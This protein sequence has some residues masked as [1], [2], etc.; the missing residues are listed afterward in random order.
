MDRKTYNTK[1]CIYIMK[2]KALF[3]LSML[4]VVL[5]GVAQPTTPTESEMKSMIDD[6]WDYNE[7]SLANYTNGTPVNSLH[8]VWLQQFTNNYLNAL[9]CLDDLDRLDQMVTIYRQAL[10]PGAM[11]ST[12]TTIVAPASCTNGNPPY[13]NPVY[14]WRAVLSEQGPKEYVLP[15]AQFGYAVTKMVNVI[16]EIPSDQRTSEMNDLLNDFQVVINDQFWRWIYGPLGHFSTDG[17]GGCSDDCMNHDDFMQRKLEKSLMNPG[18]PSY[19]NIISYREMWIIGAAAE[20]LLAHHREPASVLLTEQ[21]KVFLTDY[22]TTSTRAL[23][24]RTSYTTLTN[25]SGASV[26]GA[27]FDIG[28][29]DDHPV[30]RYSQVT[31]PCNSFPPNDPPFPVNTSTDLSHARL[32]VHIL[33]SLFTAR[34]ITGQ[35]FPDQSVMEAFANQFAYGVFNGEFGSP[36]FSNYTNGDNGWF[37]VNLISNAPFQLGRAAYFGFGFWSKYNPDIAS[38]NSC[39]YNLAIDPNLSAHR[40]AYFKYGSTDTSNCSLGYPMNFSMANSKDMLMFLPSF[41]QHHRNVPENTSLNLASGFNGS[42]G[43][44]IFN[45]WNMENLGHLRLQPSPNFVLHDMVSADF[46]LDGVDEL[47]YSVSEAAGHHIISMN[48]VYE[49]NGSTNHEPIIFAPIGTNISSLA[50]ADLDV[51]A[52]KELVY[53]MNTSGISSIYYHDVY[54]TNNTSHVYDA[55]GNCEIIDIAAGDLDNDGTNELAFISLDQYTNIYSIYTLDVIAGTSPVLVYASNPGQLIHHLEAGDVNGGA[56]ELFFD[57]TQAGQSTVYF[58][59]L[60]TGVPQITLGPTDEVTALLTQD[61]DADGVVELIYGLE[62]LAGA[63]TYSKEV[64]SS[65]ASKIHGPDDGHDVVALSIGDF[66]YQF[67]SYPSCQYSF[68]TWPN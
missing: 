40:D 33:E 62:T 42:N 46:D 1:L 26:P 47:I 21:Q 36:R 68:T 12:N 18:G 35:Q 22:L 63:E 8:L 41:F 54:A 34:P 24:S 30:V 4:L 60:I 13:S 10:Q 50:T 59:D 15:S 44:E 32:Y 14:V 6:L 64:S 38:I 19:C 52:Q 66:G 23:E 5:I 67:P 20:I 65:V 25:F 11:I 29:L 28:A 2:K 27:L 58:M 56:D 7:N 3:T 31:T 53:V 61:I 9:L 48:D 49:P 17:W 37:N 16:L 57:L 55:C 43:A 45:S 39:L 51:D